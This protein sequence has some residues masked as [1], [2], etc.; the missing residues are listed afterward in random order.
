MGSEK[1]ESTATSSKRR[2]RSIAL[3]VAG[4]L[5]VGLATLG[6]FVPLLPTTP[7]LLLAAACYMRSSDRLYEWLTHHK[8]FGTYIRSYREHRAIT[9]W[10]KILSITLLWCTMTYSAL[11]LVSSWVVRA[12]LAAIAIGVTVHLLS[13]KTA[14]PDML[15][16]QLEEDAETQAP[17][18]PIQTL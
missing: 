7:F 3:I 10:T 1:P 16:L 9:L 12:V 8:W 4:S 13:L 15:K 17:G 2:I 11:A 18:E 14:T 6:I 5:C